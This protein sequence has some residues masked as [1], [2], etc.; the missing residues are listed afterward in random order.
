MTNPALAPSIRTILAARSCGLPLEVGCERASTSIKGS[1]FA[2]GG[3]LYRAP[4]S[5]PAMLAPLEWHEQHLA[6]A[7]RYGE[8][9]DGSI[10]HRRVK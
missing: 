1:R 4:L 8:L 6:T 2:P 5:R 9:A 3:D 7:Y 10:G